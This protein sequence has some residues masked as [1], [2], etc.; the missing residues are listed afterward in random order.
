MTRCL[1]LPPSHF[2][3][4]VLYLKKPQKT[5]KSQQPD[6][7][8]DSICFWANF[9]SFR[10]NISRYSTSAQNYFFLFSCDHSYI[11]HCSL[12]EDRSGNGS[13][14][15]PAAFSLEYCILKKTLIFPV[16]HWA[17]K[18]VLSPVQEVQER[19]LVWV[20]V[21]FF[22]PVIIYISRSWKSA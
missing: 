8:K 21:F 2:T 16:L 15:L 1:K 12:K 20:V 11:S 3:L 19:E 18:V 17:M 10:N 13:C 22:P 5:T 9:A 7:P 14:Y 4:I 6:L